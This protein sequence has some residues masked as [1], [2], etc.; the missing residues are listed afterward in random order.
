VDETYLKV[1]GEW[2]YVYRTVDQYSQVINAYVSKRRNTAA[3]RRFFADASRAHGRPVEATTDLA[4]PLLRVI[5][6]LIPEAVHDTEQNA[7]SRIKNDH[8]RLKGEA[9]TD[10]RSTDGSDRSIVIRGHAFTQNVTRGHYEL[11][12]DAQSERLRLAAAFDQLAEM[13]SAKPTP[14]QQAAPVDQRCPARLVGRSR[15]AWRCD[16]GVEV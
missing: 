11:G 4:A 13:I 3:A 8:G 7:N 5:D 10:A 6:E 2:R 16:A 15:W 14:T 12:I 1:A 9:E